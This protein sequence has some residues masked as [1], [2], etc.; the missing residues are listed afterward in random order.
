MR[1]NVK[2]L[3]TNKCCRSYTGNFHNQQGH[4]AHIGQHPYTRPPTI[5][6]TG[7]RKIHDGPNPPDPVIWRLQSQ[8][9]KM[10]TQLDL[11]DSHFTA[12]TVIQQQMLKVL[13]QMSLSLQ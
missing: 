5:W 1:Y 12:S 10:E 6:I 9:E 11:M 3:S 7:G 4:T 8:Q 13:H 2:L